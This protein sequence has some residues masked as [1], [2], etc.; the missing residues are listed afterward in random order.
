M[1]LVWGTCPCIF[2]SSR[3][4]IDVG[5]VPRLLLA[6]DHAARIVVRS[7]AVVDRWPRWERSGR[8]RWGWRAAHVG[9][10]WS[11][12]TLFLGWLPPTMAC[13]AN[14][15]RGSSLPAVE[16]GALCLLDG[17]KFDQIPHLAVKV[18]LGRILRLWQCLQ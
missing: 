15:A 1:F 4:V 8:R 6:S 13:A 9:L 17:G 16:R 5:V 14:W 7:D 10:P 18:S 12:G 11:R 3:H 2:F